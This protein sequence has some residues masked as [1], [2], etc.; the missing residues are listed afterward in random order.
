M[1]K[2]TLATAA[3]IAITS[4]LLL[5]STTLAAD[6][7]KTNNTKKDPAKPTGSFINETTYGLAKIKLDNDADEEH[8]AFGST[9]K[10]GYRFANDI[11]VYLGSDGSIYKNNS[12]DYIATSVI[13]PGI[14]YTLPFAEKKFGIGL[15]AGLASNTNYSIIFK[16]FSNSFTFGSG[17]SIILDYRFYKKWS[18]G[19]RASKYNFKKENA[20]DAQ[21]ISIG[22][23]YL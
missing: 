6:T 20:A 11:A 16:D 4:S 3:V 23:G 17:G 18:V 2:L 13:G 8:F 15:I 12:G 14:S 5:S 19:I 1:R 7:R 22:I 9:S 21:S 10:S